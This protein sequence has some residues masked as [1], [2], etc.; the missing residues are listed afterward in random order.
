MTLDPLTSRLMESA[1]LLKRYYIASRYPD[2]I[3]EDVSAE[4]AA[5][6]LAA[7]TQ[8]REFILDRVL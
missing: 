5:E 1:T 6:A 8:I 4:E 3:P 2:D 7:A